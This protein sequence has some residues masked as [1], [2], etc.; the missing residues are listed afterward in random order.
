MCA[1]NSEIYLKAEELVDLKIDFLPERWS[2]SGSSNTFFWNFGWISNGEGL[3]AAGYFFTSSFAVGFTP[4]DA[5]PGTNVVTFSFNSAS[6]FGTLRSFLTGSTAVE[7][8]ISIESLRQALRDLVLDLVTT[9]LW[10]LE[11]LSNVALT[12]LVRGDF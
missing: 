6:N 7:A 11:L 8:E 12:C 1:D 3:L 9:F 2:A 10:T 5:L 4:R